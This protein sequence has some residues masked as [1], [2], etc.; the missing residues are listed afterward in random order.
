MNEQ[1]DD[2]SYCESC[3]AEFDAEDWN[4]LDVG[5]FC[6]ECLEIE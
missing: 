4:D 1:K 5:M 3:D 2:K 6:D